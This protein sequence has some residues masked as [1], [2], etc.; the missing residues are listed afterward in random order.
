MSKKK[1][2][3]RWR[4][5]YEQILVNNTLMEPKDVAKI[6]DIELFDP[7]ADNISPREYYES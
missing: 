3:E 6:E 1:S 2:F 5:E 7:W 4:Q